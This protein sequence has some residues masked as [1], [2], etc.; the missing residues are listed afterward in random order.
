MPG[1]ALAVAA[2]V[3]AAVMA[4]LGWSL[5]RPV[6]MP[7]MRASIVLP[8]GVTLD[9]ANASIALSPDGTKL[10]YAGREDNGPGKLWIRPLNTVCERNCE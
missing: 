8:A 2:V 10:A 6:P 1:W 9:S 5:H 3:G 4:G 7:S